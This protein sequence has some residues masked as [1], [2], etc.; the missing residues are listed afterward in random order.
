MS[1][2]KNS[3]VLDTSF[4]PPWGLRN[5]YAMTVFIALQA[6]RQW[7]QWTIDPEPSYRSQIFLG[8][9]NVPIFGWVAVPESPKGTIVGTYGITGTLE[10]QWFLQL[11]GRKAFA[12]GY[13][14]VLFDW[15]AH[16]K[17]AELSPTLTSDGIYEGQDFVH[18]AAKA[19]ALGCPPPFWFTGYSLGGQLALWGI[20]EASHAENF[21]DLGIEP[22]DLRG[23]AVICP[24][25][26]SHR[27]LAYLMNDP[28]GKHLE[29]GIAR[30]LKQ[31]AL[32]IRQY[33]PGSLDPAA[34][35][36]AN[37]IWG[38]DHEL[39]I[40]PLGFPSVE[41]YYDA[42]SPLPLLP[43]LTKPTLI[44]YAADDPL[45]DPTIVPDLQA[46][47]ASNEAIDLMLTQYGGHVG[48]FSSKACQR[49]FGDCDPW[50]AWNRILEWIDRQS[51]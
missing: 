25:L 2:L 48:Y 31:L 50:W 27:S 22:S 12:Q 51:A 36:R 6:S 35:D 3:G 43:H 34:I 42:S 39:V 24:S 8:Q 18:I 49:R 4:L 21:A 13:A 30:A 45:F 32:E 40:K 5:G 20:Q 38:F 44:L 11:L 14:V 15:R 1:S 33:H 17:T 41:A 47:C 10:N 23:G 37:S 26:D 28:L 29:R 19:K 16:G 7:Q 46:A 9:G